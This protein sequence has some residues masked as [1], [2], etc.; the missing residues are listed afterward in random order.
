MGLGKTS[1][2]NY[3]KYTNLD[4]VNLYVA[5]F[6]NQFNGNATEQTVPQQTDGQNTNM[7]KINEGEMIIQSRQGRWKNHSCQLFIIPAQHD[8]EKKKN[9]L[10][11]AGT[12]SVT[13]DNR[14]HIQL[15]KEITNDPEK[16]IQK[17]SSNIL[18]VGAIQF[19]L[20]Q[21]PKN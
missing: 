5:N 19:V 1:I 17:R 18:P 6:Y 9:I 15:L 10:R 7:L 2:I 4:E 3:L 21:A 20:K 14:C 8:V 13:V 11:N 16:L 12:W